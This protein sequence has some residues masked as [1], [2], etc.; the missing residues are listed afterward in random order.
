MAGPF[1]T[2][3]HASRS[4]GG[5]S[6]CG[7]IMKTQ[8]SLANR[9]G[10][11]LLSTASLQPVTVSSQTPQFDGRGWAVGNHQETDRESLTEYV[12]PG[13][14]V[15]TWRELVTSTVF[16]Q[17]VPIAAF[18][19]RIHTL[20]AKDC[21]SL[22]WNV[23]QEDERTALFE[24]RDAGCGGFEAQHELDRVTIEPDGLYRLAY[25]AKTK[26]PLPEER[27][28]QWLALLTQTPLVERAGG[29]RAQPGKRS[30][31]GLDNA[32][33]AA[34]QKIATDQLAAAVRK[35]GG[36]C[37]A[38]VKSEVKGKTAGPQG[39]LIESIVECS[40]GQRYT[41][42]IDPSGSVTSFLISK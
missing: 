37:P 38:G 3:W 34:A 35:S 31:G 9:V 17:P 41:V 30:A 4:S 14:T 36:T 28:K 23:I 24:F 39:P 12:L 8:T 22:E 6:M 13:Q 20:M 40:N 27:R 33:L 1:G 11:V 7:A 15:D 19:E 2:A 25:A 32:T 10:V 5:L 18:V 29:V 16:V 21:P 26:A 42:F